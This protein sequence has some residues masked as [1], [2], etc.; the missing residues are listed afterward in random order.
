MFAI[1]GYTNGLSWCLQ[2]REQDI[3]NAI[4]LVNVAQNRLR[5][6][7]S[8]GWDQ[9]LQKVTLIHNKYGVQVPAVDD[10]YVP[11][12][13]SA[14]HARNQTNDD[15]FRREVYSGVI[16]HISQKLIIVLMR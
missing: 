2:R 14:R 16:G 13:K 10:N 12:G 5:K 11:Y 1:L 3:L 8:N 9:F 15:H 7:R 4:S 6:L